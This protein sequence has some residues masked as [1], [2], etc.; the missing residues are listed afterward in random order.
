MLLEKWQ[1]F[2]ELNGNCFDLLKLN[3]LNFIIK[4]LKKE[5]KVA[6]LNVL[7]KIFF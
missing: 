5:L 3:C 7:N 1:K 6:N 2:V 4:S